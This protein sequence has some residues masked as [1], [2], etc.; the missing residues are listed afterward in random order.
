MRTVF[1]YHPKCLLHDTGAHHPERPYRLEAILRKLK[2]SKLIER[3]L[4]LEPEPNGEEIE[5]IREVH[6]K[7]YVD[8]IKT[9]SKKGFFYLDPDTVVSK[10]T[11]EAARLAVTCVLKGADLVMENNVENGFCAVRPPGHHAFSDKGSGFCIFNNVAIATKYLQKRYNLRKIL[12][13]DWDLHHGNGTQQIFYKDRCVLYI[14][15]HLYPYYPGTGSDGEIG[16]GE[17]KG[18]NLNIPMG[19]GST[20]SDYLKA[21]DNIIFPKAKDFK[22]EFILISAGFDGHKEDPLSGISLTEEGFY[23]MTR[24]VKDMAKE[25]CNGRV[26]SILEGGYNL[27]SLAASVEA[28]LRGLM[29]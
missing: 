23:E 27:F 26:L 6:T 9:V 4:F 8:F 18:F 20:N 11:F 21:F 24:R 13:L 19:A 3:V 17:G 5:W 10:G 28:H 16:E 2:Q 25:L 29:E 22:P 15:L 12:I 7:D 14:S 1:L